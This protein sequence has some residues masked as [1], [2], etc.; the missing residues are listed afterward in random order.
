MGVQVPS[1]RLATFLAG[2]TM[3]APLLLAA[4]LPESPRWLLATGRKVSIPVSAEHSAP[5]RGNVRHYKY[6]I[7]SCKGLPAFACCTAATHVEADV[8]GR[9][10]LPPG[11]L[12]PRAVF[13]L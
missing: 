6:D 10:S 2:V 9:Q 5:R 12:C 8:T 11:D 3:A 7:V 13:N 4:Y 1:W